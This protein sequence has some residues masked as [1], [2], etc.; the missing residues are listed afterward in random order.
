MFSVL[1]QIIDKTTLR[2]LH[3]YLETDD[4]EGAV[5]VPEDA[6]ANPLAICKAFAQLAVEGGKHS[7][8]LYF[9]RN[10]LG[11]QNLCII[12]ASHALLPRPISPY[13]SLTLTK[14][15]PPYLTRHSVTDSERTL[16][17]LPASTLPKTYP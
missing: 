12:F 10:M 17:H 5:W 8:I 13:M 9:N 4:I 7:Q 6:V 16:V 14:S 15:S 1:F 3:P 2:N 11:Y